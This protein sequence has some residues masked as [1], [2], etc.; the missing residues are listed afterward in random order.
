MLTGKAIPGTAQYDGSY[1][2]PGE[3]P[4]TAQTGGQFVVP[5]LENALIGLPSAERYSFNFAF[6]AQALDHALLNGAAQARFERVIHG[7][8][9]SDAPVSDEFDAA[10]ARRSSDHDALLLY[11]NRSSTRPSANGFR[12]FRSDFE[13]P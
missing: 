10:T 3:L 11:S 12:I 9:N 4:C 2:P 1:W 5:G 8:G 7:R 13:T 6:A